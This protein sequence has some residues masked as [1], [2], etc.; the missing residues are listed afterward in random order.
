LIPRLEVVEEVTV[1]VVAVPIIAIIKRAVI[2][3]VFEI[4]LLPV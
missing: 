2:S 1:D 4:F 3:L